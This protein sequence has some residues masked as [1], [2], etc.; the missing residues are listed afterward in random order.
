VL[1]GPKDKHQA[2]R[3]AY[4]SG[5]AASEIT[6]GG[7]RIA[8]RRPRAR[9]VEGEELELPS[10]AVFANRDPLDEHTLSSIAAGVTTRQYAL[11]LERLPAAEQDRSSSRSS[12]SCRFV[13]LS[14]LQL[15]RWLS[16]R[17]EDLHIRVVMIDGK[18]F[19]DHV[20]LITLG[21]GE[22][23]QKHVLGLREGT[24][25]NAAVCRALLSDLIER[26]LPMDRRLLFVIDG[27]KGLRAG[28][29]ECFGREAV[30]QRCLTHKIRNVLDHLP[31]AM[32][33]SVHAALRRAWGSKDP[34]LARRQL[35]QLARGLES[36][37]HGAAAAILE[38]LDEQLT[39][40]R[41]K[42]QGA[43]ARVLRT[44]NA[45]ENLMGSVQRYTRNVKRWRGA[46]MIVRW[47]A[48]AVLRA[49]RSFRAVHGYR[50]I[51][52]LTRALQAVDFEKI[53]A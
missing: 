37:H 23:G 20:V 36:D 33:P 18:V 27:G 31:D 11:T 41:L 44:T 26:G 5:S 8:M 39:V 34:K 35:Q 28:I 48:A 51:P 40:Q 17:I 47:A 50:D 7:R 10:F 4:R 53:A 24:T 13:A 21:I 9:S 49:Q 29:L 3:Q 19:R 25:E 12:V 38:G 6:L 46:K 1:C 15:E 42:L 16:Q 32:K 52:K 45:I 30:V 2:D 43:L 22:N 14:T